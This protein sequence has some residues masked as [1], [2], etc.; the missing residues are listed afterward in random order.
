MN[1]SNRGH[2]TFDP[3][4]ILD[5]MPNTFT[6][7]LSCKAAPPLIHKRS[8]PFLWPRPSLCIRVFSLS[9]FLVVQTSFYRGNFRWYGHGN[10]VHFT[11][12][13]HNFRMWRKV[14]TQV[15]LVELIRTVCTVRTILPMHLSL[16]SLLHLLIPFI[17]QVSLSLH[18][19]SSSQQEV[20]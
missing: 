13:L 6:A 11:L 10:S 16:Q 8:S 3:F 7:C 19:N 2:H 18:I 9:L 17:T 12:S 1:P 14:E 4:G 5:Q 20:E 15:I